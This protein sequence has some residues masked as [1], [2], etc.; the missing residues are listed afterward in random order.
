MLIRNVG[1]KREGGG[2]SDAEVWAVWQKGTVV[3]GYDGNQIRKDRCGAWMR[4]AE[5]GMTTDAGWEIDHDVP[6]AKGG[7]DAL[8]NL[9]PLYW[10]NNRHKGDSYPQWSCLVP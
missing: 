7:S 5:Y 2:F 6:V 8:Y 4:W 3:P 10:R 9:Q 1:T